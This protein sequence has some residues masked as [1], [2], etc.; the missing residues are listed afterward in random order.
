MD[1]P[2]QCRQDWEIILDLA[3]RRARA[4][5]ASRMSLEADA[6]NRDLI[7]WYQHHGYRIVRH[8]KDYYTRRWHAYRFELPLPARRPR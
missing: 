2:G 4:R 3:K 8:L 6:R 5:G 1:P 7:A